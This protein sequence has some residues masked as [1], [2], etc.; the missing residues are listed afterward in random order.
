[1]TVEKNQTAATSTLAA[2]GGR[3]Y[4]D[5]EHFDYFISRCRKKYIIISTSLDSLEFHKNKYLI[6]S[7]ITSFRGN[8]QNYK[9][10]SLLLLLGLRYQRKKFTDL[11][12]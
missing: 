10:R 8:Y 2:A 12:S 6:L 4:G 11:H 3:S 1:L 9:K 5:W 7:L